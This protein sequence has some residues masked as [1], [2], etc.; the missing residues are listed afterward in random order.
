MPNITYQEQLTANALVPTS[1][2]TLSHLPLDN[3]LMVFINGI[4]QR[5]T[6]DYIPSGSYV[7]TTSLIPSGYD[8][9]V[10]YSYYSEITIGPSDLSHDPILP[11]GRRGST[12][13]NHS[14][15]SY[16]L[17]S[18]RIK[19][20]LGWPVT[21]V[22][23]CDD[24][25][26]SYIDQG[27]EWYSKYAGY[28]EEYM[29]F[30]ANRSYKYGYGIKMDDIINRLYC[31]HN[32]CNCQ[33]GR[34]DRALITAQY[35]D[36]D[37]NDYRKVVDVFSLDPVEFTG[38]DVLFTMDYLFAQQTYFSYMLGSFGFD[39]ITWHILKD[40][41][42]LREKMFATKPYIRFDNR[43]QILK[44]MPEP[45]PQNN[46]YGVIGLRV[47]K[48]ISQLVQE[49]WVQRY[50]LA[51]T[52]ISLAHIRGKFGAVTLFGGA[53]LNASDMMTQGLEMKKELEDEIMKTYGEVE[54]PYFFMG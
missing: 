16:E 12:T 53:S 39:L 10:S 21:Q 34:T 23:L 19:Y 25:I 36:C 38:T 48:P 2:F 18:D 50:A 29:V 45:T 31:W 26:Y 51:L 14:V 22:E 5:T 20:Q 15:T 7:Y 46:F 49:R 1:A 35:V 42:S 40:W 43:T 6:T 27:I 44:L 54:P 32:F 37:L 28:T 13:L 52:M 17:L 8:I 24:Q 9:R 30:D 3:T 33:Q 4:Y 11:Q 41:L 47:E